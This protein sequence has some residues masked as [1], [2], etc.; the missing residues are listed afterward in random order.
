[1]NIQCTLLLANIIDSSDHFDD[2]TFQ[3]DRKPMLYLE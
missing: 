1:M 3:A 2:A